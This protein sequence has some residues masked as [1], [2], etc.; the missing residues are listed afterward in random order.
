MKISS[1]GLNQ[2]IFNAIPSWSLSYMTVLVGLVFLR[3]STK[4]FAV[5]KQYCSILYKMAN[6]ERPTFSSKP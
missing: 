5:K 3:E 6:E 2:A 1:Q 4:L